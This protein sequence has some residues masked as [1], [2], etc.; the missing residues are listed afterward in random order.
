MKRSL[1]LIL[2]ACAPVFA[3][4]DP[5][6]PDL[7]VW[8]RA[9]DL[10]AAGLSPGDFIS[11]W[12]DASSYGTI[13][14]PRTLSNPN[15]PGAGFPVEEAPTLQLADINGNMVPSV[16]FDRAGQ[17]ERSEVF[18]SDTLCPLPNA[19][20]GDPNIPGSGAADRL[21]QTN[22]LAPNFDPLNIGNGTS[23]TTFAV[24]KPDTTSSTTNGFNVIM[25]KRGTSESVWEMGIRDFTGHFNNVIY[26]AITEYRSAHVPIEGIWH[27]SSTKFIDDPLD[28]MNPN[29][30][31]EWWDD[32]SQDPNQR[33]TD[34]GVTPQNIT[35]NRNTTVAEPF[36]IGAHSQDC[37]GELETFVGNIAELLVY[38]RDLT[39]TDFEDVQA[40]LNNKYF[41]SATVDCDF[42]GD[43]NCDGTDID[44]LV[45]ES[46]AGTNDPNFDLTGDG[47]VDRNDVNDPNDG[48]L[49]RA[50]EQNIGP[51]R[52]YL[53]GDANLDE[54][55]DGPDFLSWNTNKFTNLAAWTGGD[56]TADGTIDGQDFLIWNTNKFMSADGHGAAVPEPAS[57]C[58][59]LLF[60]FAFWRRTR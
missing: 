51:G 57:F 8:M 49:R 52:A 6:D 53:E 15:G 12:V 1:V 54:T 45:A 25:A 36:G 31:V 2:L 59:L 26:D 11:Q 4:P 50:G 10:V 44:M 24:F 58:L 18:G 30:L 29:D 40:Y 32:E 5:T 9:D 20:E 35:Q 39:P 34:R 55:V 14:E 22:N 46:A 23:L 28:P 21:Y 47:I 42:S 38:A 17:P 41:A 33:M 43:G 60:G 48:W 7:R 19:C 16:R 27:I 3:D 56:F 37:C 13:M